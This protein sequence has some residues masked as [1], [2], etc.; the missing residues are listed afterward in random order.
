MPY[1]DIE[2]SKLDLDL[3]NPR[4]SNVSSQQEAMRAIIASQDRE[5]QNLL[6]NLALDI[7]ARG[8]SPIQNFIVLRM[9]NERFTVLDGNRRL[10]A[11]RLLD[12]PSSLPAGSGPADFAD[13]AG[14][15]G[16]H[17]TVIRCFV[18]NRRAD[19]ADWLERTHTGQ[20]DGLGTV[21]WSPTAKHR[22]SPVG[23]PTQVS[24]AVAA[25]DWLRPRVGSAAQASVDH[26]EQKAAT[27]L[28]RLVSTPTVRERIGFRFN[29]AAVVLDAPEGDVVRRL[30]KV[31]DDLAGGRSVGD[32]MR[33]EQREDY[34][35]D[36]LEADVHQSVQPSP[37]RPSPRST[38]TPPPTPPPPPKLFSD[39]DVSGLHQRIQAIFRELRELDLAR[40]PNAAAV[41]LRSAIQLSVD[42]Y[43]EAI[44]QRPSPKTELKNLIKKAVEEL[45]QNPSDPRFESIMTDLSKQHGLTT[46]RNLHQYVHNLNNAPLIEDLATISSHYKP[47]IDEISASLKARAASGS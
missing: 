5:N 33:T 24:R 44:G 43:L 39:V 26:V 15:A 12:N 42:E 27:N 21:A 32:I 6:A 35:D 8:L 4:H 38:S 16:Q 45:R 34:I 46:A 36:L 30:C 47:L 20:L 25:I 40:F 10:A 9:E 19:A 17:P 22:F 14:E 23:R 3:Q 7:H 1:E 13:R 28:G 41:L 29:G 31:I 2:V 11:L 37:P 18:V